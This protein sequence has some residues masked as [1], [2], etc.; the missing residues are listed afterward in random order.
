VHITK[1]AIYM[2]RKNGVYARTEIRVIE[3]LNVHFAVWAGDADVLMYMPYP[4]R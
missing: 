4:I 2:Y 1:Q 3:N